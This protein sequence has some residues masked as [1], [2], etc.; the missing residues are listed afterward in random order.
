[1]FTV[2]RKLASPAVRVRRTAGF[3]FKDVDEQIY[4]WISQLWQ[5]VN[6]EVVAT[7]LGIRVHV[8]ADQIDEARCV[9]AE[10]YVNHKDAVSRR[11]PSLAAAVDGVT[12]IL[13][14]LGLL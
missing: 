12:G 14:G 5:K 9:Y 4:R 13:A 10:D 1:M 2:D 11:N 8:W 3:H 7:A 6:I